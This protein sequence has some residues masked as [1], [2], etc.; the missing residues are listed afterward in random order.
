MQRLRR[1]REPVSNLTPRSGKVINTPLTARGSA[2][3]VWARAERDFVEWWGKRVAAHDEARTCAWRRV[4]AVP[5]PTDEVEGRLARSGPPTASSG[6]MR[7]LPRLS[8][9]PQPSVS[10]ARPTV[11][12]SPSRSHRAW[13]GPEG[14]RVRTA[15]AL[16]GPGD[17]A[18]R[19]TFTTMRQMIRGR[20]HGGGIV[21]SIHESVDREVRRAAHVG[22]GRH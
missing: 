18:I 11:A 21:F 1:R 2:I 5:A 14:G 22:L 10:L 7:I 16:G 20:A 19:R 12:C 13:A 4:H 9:T 6:R 3:G 15:A 17:A 8:S